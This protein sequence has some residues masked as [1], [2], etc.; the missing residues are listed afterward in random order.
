V[1]PARLTGLPDARAG[2]YAAAA[3]CARA[4]QGSGCGAAALAEPGGD[5]GADAAHPAPPMLHIWVN[6]DMAVSAVRA[7]MHSF[8][9]APA[10]QSWV[11]SRARGGRP[12]GDQESP[13]SLRLAE[14]DLLFAKLDGGQAASA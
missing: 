5:G 12:L 7:S 11:L 3:D 2:E 4:G 1:S 13:Q 6:G 9:A 14:G 8:V 10:G